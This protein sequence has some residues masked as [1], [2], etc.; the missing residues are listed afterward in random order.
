MVDV[1]RQDV[2]YLQGGY[3]AWTRAGYPLEPK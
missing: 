2:R 3:E 1:G